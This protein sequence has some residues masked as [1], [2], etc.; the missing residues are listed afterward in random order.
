M[1]RQP[2]RFFAGA[3][4]GEAVVD[5]LGSQ[6]QRLYLEAF[7]L[8]RHVLRATVRVLFCRC[9]DAALAVL[10]TWVQTYFAR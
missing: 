3:V 9:C 2:C 7:R 8:V 6:S 5:G 1:A 4:A 10:W